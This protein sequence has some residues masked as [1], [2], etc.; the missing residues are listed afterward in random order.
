ML[1]VILSDDDDDRRR[2]R[3]NG[4]H[5]NKLH[6]DLFCFD[7]DYDDDDDDWLR[8]TTRD[9]SLAHKGRVSR[10]LKDGIL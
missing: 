4:D 5:V 3:R 8:M 9:C 2:R 6:N 1:F 7:V 10:C